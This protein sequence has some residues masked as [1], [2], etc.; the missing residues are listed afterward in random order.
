MAKYMERITFYLRFVKIFSSAFAIVYVIDS[1]IL[2]ALFDV[3]IPINFLDLLSLF[4]YLNPFLSNG[5]K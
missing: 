4:L 5:K 3:I 2:V 1:K